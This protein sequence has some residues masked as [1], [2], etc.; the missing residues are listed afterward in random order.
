VFG[1]SPNSKRK[2]FLALHRTETQVQPKGTVKAKLSISIG[3]TSLLQRAKAKNI[4][5][6]FQKTSFKQILNTK[7]LNSRI[8]KFVFLALLGL[9]VI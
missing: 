6:K 4:N 9:F 5:F 7:R 3:G 1:Q 2:A 8:F